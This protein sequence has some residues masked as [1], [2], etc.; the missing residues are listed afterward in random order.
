MK[1]VADPYLRHLTP[2]TVSQA[3]MNAKRAMERHNPLADPYDVLERAARSAGIADEDDV[4]M[5]IAYFLDCYAAE[6]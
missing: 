2:R 4:E 1:R 6:E 5:F 3:W